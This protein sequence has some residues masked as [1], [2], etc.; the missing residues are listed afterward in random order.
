MSS[1]GEPSSA[2]GDTPRAPAATGAAGCV[3]LAADGAPSAAR[4]LAAHRMDFDTMR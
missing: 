3:E 4:A 2:R 1:N